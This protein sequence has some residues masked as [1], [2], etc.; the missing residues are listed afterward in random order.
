MHK[1]F[2]AIAVTA[3]A[4]IL[5]LAQVA[6]VSAATLAL[7]FN[8]TGRS[9]IGWHFLS[10]SYDA[11]N[12]WNLTAGCQPGKCGHLG[13]DY[14]AKDWNVGGGDYDCGR[15]VLAPF[16]GTVLFKSS[17]G[18]G[19]G[20]QVIIQSAANSNFAF[21]AAH[22][23]S[24]S[25]TT[26]ATVVQGEKI[27]KVGKSGNQQYCHLHSVLYKNIK[28]GL[29]A[30]VTGL[31][32]LKLGRTLGLSG[33]ANTFAADYTADANLDCNAYNGIFRGVGVFSSDFCNGSRMLFQTAG[34]VNLPDSGWND[35]VN[36]VY[37]SSGSSVR[38]W[39][40][41]YRGGPSAC[42]NIAKWNLDLDRYTD[43]SVI[44]NSI[45]SLQIYTNSTCS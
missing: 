28:T 3:F 26:K 16:S 6:P 36:S 30:G 17:T 18:D 45:S 37:I 23:Q 7:S 41:A 20:Y 31:S 21:R 40:D 25:L 24:G 15:D 29:Y 4:A 10:S 34:F 44:S 32:R 11:P 39:K 33:A 14:Y 42:F 8:S 27:G 1:S 22:M 2:S 43:G 12:G 5:F 13:S 38:V 9:H 35:R 19:Y